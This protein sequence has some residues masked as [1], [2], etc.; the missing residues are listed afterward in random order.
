LKVLYADVGCRSVE[1]LAEYVPYA[2][3]LLALCP[4]R[5][6][7]SVEI[8]IYD[9]AERPY[10]GLSIPDPPP[11]FAALTSRVRSPLNRLFKRLGAPP[12]LRK[13]EVVTDIEPA[14][15]AFRVTNVK[16]PI[17]P[18]RTDAHAQAGHE[19]ITQF[20]DFVAAGTHG[21]QSFRGQGLN[22][23]WQIKLSKGSKKVPKDV[24]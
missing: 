14:S 9:T 21:L 8:G 24:R 3:S 4:Q 5:S 19:T 20:D 17:P 18:T 23:L 16:R 6:P 7:I 15:F 2:R 1:V 12:S 11:G 13:R 10:S 22:T